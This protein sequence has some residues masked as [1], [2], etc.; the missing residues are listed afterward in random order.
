MFSCSAN[1]TPEFF[2]SS[3]PAQPQDS[4]ATSLGAEDTENNINGKNTDLSRNCFFND[5]K[6][7]RETERRL[8]RKYIHKESKVVAP[9]DYL[10]N[11][12]K[13]SALEGKSTCIK[14]SK[15]LSVGELI[16]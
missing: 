16:R 14:M 7:Y 9:R 1:A 15:D 13:I 8:E 11:F 12:S 6:L 5:R 10:S 2:V 3:N 4:A